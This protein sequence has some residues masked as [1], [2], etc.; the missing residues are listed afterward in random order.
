[1]K[2]LGF[3]FN[4]INIEKFSS[5]KK[6]LKINTN[7]NI[8]EIN[9]I[10]TEIFK[11]NEELL[12]IRFSYSI[13]YEPNFANLEFFGNILLSLDLK[14]IKEVL[15]KWKDKE[16]P[17]DFRIALFNLIIRKSSIKALE[18]EEEMDIPYHIP[19]PTLKKQEDYNKD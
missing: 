6:E 5:E 18:F 7:I 13:K 2:L 12:E 11:T 8:L 19:I 10:Q 16:I 9:K 15:K 3:S 4:K 14:M 1:M 17:D